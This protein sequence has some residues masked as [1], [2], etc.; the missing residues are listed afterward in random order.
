MTSATSVE[1]EEAVAHNP[2]RYDD[3][4]DTIGDRWACEPDELQRLKQLGWEADEQPIRD[5][6]IH[7]YLNDRLDKEEAVGNEH[8]VDKYRGW[9]ANEQPA[10]FEPDDGRE[11]RANPT[12]KA[13]EPDTETI[14]Q[15]RVFDTG[16][17]R[18][19][20]EGKVDL[21]GYLSPI[22]LMEYGKHMLAA[23]MGGK[24]SSDN[25]QKGM[26]LE[27]YMKSMFRHF[28]TVWLK[29]R[30]HQKGDIVTDLMAMWFNVQGYTH[31]V[32]KKR[33]EPMTATEVR[34]REKEAFARFGE[35]EFDTFGM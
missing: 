13:P 10:K 8:Y 16:A 14:T 25:W 31:E 28:H 2:K 11:L 22:A 17:K 30:G 23:E 18:S 9:E 32:L 19:S 1:K 4:G 7:G 3:S 5:P 20:A 26:P 24:R 12:P 15:D 35:A 6:Y 27:D 29:H 34:E 33:N 21:E